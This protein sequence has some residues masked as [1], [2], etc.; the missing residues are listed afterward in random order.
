MS[1]LSKVPSITI[2]H[3]CMCKV[4]KQNI[5][6]GHIAIPLGIHHFHYKII[7]YFRCMI[8]HEI[9]GERFILS[10]FIPL[11][12]CFGTQNVFYLIKSLDVE[13][14]ALRKIT[15]AKMDFMFMKQCSINI[16][17]TMWIRNLLTSTPP[18]NT[19]P[20]KRTL[21]LKMLR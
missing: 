7:K 21:F 2:G 16:H 17:K 18:S 1:T 10:L 11:I 19:Q 20:K 13:H 3:S 6:I 8:Y 9:I 12:Q 15:Q 14:L 5:N 4:R